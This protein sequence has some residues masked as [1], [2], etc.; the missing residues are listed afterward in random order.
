MVD[1]GQQSV[2]VTIY[3]DAWTKI[4]NETIHDIVD[5]R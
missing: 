1:E 5:K 2:I 3:A 4:A